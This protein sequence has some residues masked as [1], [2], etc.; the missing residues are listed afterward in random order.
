[1]STTIPDVATWREIISYE[2]EEF[3][4]LSKIDS[5]KIE[6][7]MLLN[8]YPIFICTTSILALF[9]AVSLVAT[10]TSQYFLDWASALVGLIGTVGLT[11]VGLFSKRQIRK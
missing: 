8:I 4:E 7:N 6:S 3:I 1:M 9:F 10:L 5:G 2:R 11:F